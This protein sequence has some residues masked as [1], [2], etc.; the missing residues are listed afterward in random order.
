MILGNRKKKILFCLILVFGV[1]RSFS[2]ADTALNQIGPP[3]VFAKATLIQNEIDLI[4]L[5]MGKSKTSLLD[6]SIS[7]AQPHEVYFQALT[8]YKKVDRLC[9][10]H[11]GD[12]G[13]IPPKLKQGNIMPSDVFEILTRA[14]TRIRC[15][16]NK[17]NITE[18][19]DEPSP[20]LN[21]TPSDVYK[22]ILQVNRQLNILLDIPYSPSTVYQQFQE[23]NETIAFLIRYENPD[24][25]LPELP[26]FVRK[27][28]PEDVFFQT[29]KCLNLLRQISYTV[30]VKILELRAKKTKTLI[31]PG[32]VYDLI[33]LVLA[34][35]KN[36]GK[37]I[38][39]ETFESYDKS[40]AF[41][42]RKLPSHV[43]QKAVYLEKLLLQLKATVSKSKISVK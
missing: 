7:K 4:R 34:G 41:P 5:E 14:R 39:P 16:L 30:G 31:Y 35:V 42:E 10:D 24:V 9:F 12:I 36:I 29:E 23:T 19:A 43:Y 26:E 21:H 33:S 15:V 17:W 6:I 20:N 18:L 13:N 3:H 25:K 37:R 8:L 11:T 27:K 28:R 2:W 1:L 40:I 38:A 32:D 22:K